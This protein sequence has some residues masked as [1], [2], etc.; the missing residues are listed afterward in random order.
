MES[1][2]TEPQKDIPQQEEKPKASEEE[3]EQRIVQLQIQVFQLLRYIRSV[4]PE[5]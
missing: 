1:K 5:D 2:Q 4:S 3:R